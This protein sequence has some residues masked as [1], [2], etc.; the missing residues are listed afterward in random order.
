VNILELFKTNSFT[1]RPPEKQFLTVPVHQQ[2]DQ[3]PKQAEIQA[4]LTVAAAQVVGSGLLW[5]WVRHDGTAKL[6]RWDSVQEVFLQGSLT[7]WV[8]FFARHWRI[9]D[10][11]GQEYLNS[12]PVVTDRLIQA[13]LKH[14]DLPI[15]SWAL[16][17]AKKREAK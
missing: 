7:D 16:Q 3:E 13:V 14:P 5:H 17:L 4:V 10:T 6:C 8:L 1:Q 9:R 2:I 15:A 12:S 11:T